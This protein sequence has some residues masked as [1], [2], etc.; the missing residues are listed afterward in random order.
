MF[1]EL[2]RRIPNPLVGQD[3]FSS[4][5]RYTNIN[6]SGGRLVFKFVWPLMNGSFYSLVYDFDVA[7]TF[8]ASYQ[9]NRQNE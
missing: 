4:V 3:Q 7:T 2:Y 6:K 5:A 1:I 8:A 9:L